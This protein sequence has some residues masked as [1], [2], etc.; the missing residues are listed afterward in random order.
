MLMASDQVDVVGFGPC[1]IRSAVAP[2][3]FHANVPDDRLAARKLIR[4]LCPKAPGV[5]GMVDPG[6]ALIY[7]GKSKSLR[8]RLLS[9]FQPE[10]EEAKACQIIARTRTLCWERAEHEFVALLRELDLIRRY[11]PGFNVQGQ[12]GR[13]RL[14]YVCIGRQPAPYVYVA[15]EPSRRSDHVFGPLRGATRLQDAVRL[16]NDGLGLRDCPDYVPMIF[17]EQLQ[18][19]SEE[20]TARCL[21]YEMQNCLAPCTGA[22]SSAEYA[23]AVRS[24][25]SFLSGTDQTLIERYEL[26]MKAA[27]DARQFERAAALR[28]AWENLVWLADQLERLR[29][30]RGRHAFVYELD[31]FERGPRWYLFFGGRVQ[32]I[33]EPPT[34]L[35]RARKAARQLERVYESDRFK[36]SG[37]PREDLEAIL[38]AASWFR[39]FPAELDRTLLPAEARSRCA[40]MCRPK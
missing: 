37:A 33:V 9:Y 19:F 32:A 12:P 29:W 20:R 6:G 14:S 26:E 15:G 40:T 28:D 23:S 2:E 4:Q 5:Y 7:V 38:L 27:A 17:A 22:C 30:F 39:R 34:N 16:L 3:C 18:M 10:D 25:R 36:S 11:K 24:A 1:S 21:R 35:R 13:R 8:G 31:T